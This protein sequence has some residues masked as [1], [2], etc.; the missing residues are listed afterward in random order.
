MGSMITKEIKMKDWF[1]NYEI[2][3]FR[4]IMSI[5]VYLFFIIQSTLVISKSKG[6]YEILWDILTSTYQFCKIVE[7]K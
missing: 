7:K 2:L 6:L 1:K 3:K 5:Q 4:L